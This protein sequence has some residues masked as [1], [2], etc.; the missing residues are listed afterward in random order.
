LNTRDALLAAASLEFSTAFTGSST[1]R[2]CDRLIMM[3]M[4]MMIMMIMMMI[5]MMIL[6]VVML[7]IKIRLVEVIMS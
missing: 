5:M 7:P 4:M 6:R 2:Y 3:M 1:R